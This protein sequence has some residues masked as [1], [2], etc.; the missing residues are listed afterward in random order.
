MEDQDIQMSTLKYRIRDEIE[1]ENPNYVKVVTDRDGFALYFSRSPIPF[2]RDFRSKGV[3]YK[4]LGFYAYTLKVLEAFRSLPVGALESAEKL[5]QLRALENDFKIKVVETA[6]D[7]IE[8][9]TPDNIDQL[10]KIVTRSD[11]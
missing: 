7:S 10:E 2:F 4:H 1:V 8:V 11:L 9:D 5:E 3:Y 6:F